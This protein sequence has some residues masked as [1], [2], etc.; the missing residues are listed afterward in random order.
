MPALSPRPGPTLSAICAGL[1][2]L[3]LLIYGQVW[4]FEFV[5]FDDNVFVYENPQVQSGL[6]PG[7]LAWAVTSVEQGN[8]QPLTRLSLLIDRELYGDFAGGFHLTNLLLHTLC[9]LV[10]FASLCRLTGA[11]FRSA[12]VAALF[13]VH[14]LNVETVAWV[15]ERKGVL[16]TLFF[17]LAVMAYVN[18]VRRRRIT[19]F[20]LLLLAYLASLCSKQ[21]MVTL[22][23][24]LLLLDVWPLGRTV[25]STGIAP[26]TVDRTNRQKPV[27]RRQLLEKLPLFALSL[28]FS[29]VAWCTQQHG[30]AVQTLL[31]VPLHLRLANA[32]VAY[33]TYLRR[34][35]WPSSLAFYYPYPTG[36]LPLAEVLGSAVLLLAVTAVC[37]Q[38][39]RNRPHLLVG[40]LWFLGTL[41]PV[42]GIVQL[43]SQQ[44]ADRYM[45]VP[46]IGLCLMAAFS[47]PSLQELPSS[48]RRLT[49]AVTAVIVA[50]LAGLAAGQA[51]SWRNSVSLFERAVNVTESNHRARFL[52]AVARHE[53]GEHEAERQQYRILDKLDH[54]YLI[55]ALNSRGEVMRDQFQFA[56]ARYYF[57]RARHYSPGDLRSAINLGILSAMEGDYAASIK[58]FRR[59]LKNHPDDARVHTLL[60]AVLVRTGNIS[61]ASE[62]A[63]RAR[64]IEAESSR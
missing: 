50:S 45:Y 59:I 15:S 29:G 3:P 33:A 53:R 14:P 62:H 26:P 11:Y 8:W 43:G 42:I 40:W 34:M 64:Q 31:S 54:Q 46:G 9:T 36:G 2:L 55:A 16:S 1:V 39:R 5:A 47:L 61:E 22:P 12:L 51:G 41:L 38:Q 30:G 63:N 24:L 21:M 13:S 28:L 4:S 25:A 23:F 58:A 49:V 56:E 17:L 18:F 10:L 32:V 52:L 57:E 60:A 7:S 20:L 48:R 6:N 27:L 44:M 19:D 37:L 35:I